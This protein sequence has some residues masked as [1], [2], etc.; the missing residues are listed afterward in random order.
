MKLFSAWYHGKALC[1]RLFFNIIY[2]KRLKLGY[3]TTWRRNFSILIS[4]EAHVNI[5]KNCFFN[6]DCSLVAMKGIDIG[7]GTLLGENV[8]IYD[9]NHRFNKINLPIKK[10]GYSLKEIK[11]GSHCWIG[12]NAIILKG[13]QIGNNCVIGAGCVI[14]QNIPDNTIVKLNSSYILEKVKVVPKG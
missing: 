4:K 9:N 3:K 10:Q 8:K 13:V 2:G 6:N 7:E 11:I 14:T 12:S 5:G 1:K